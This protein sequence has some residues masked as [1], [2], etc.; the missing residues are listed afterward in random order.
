M[1]GPDTV[2][3]TLGFWAGLYI[4]LFL[5]VVVGGVALIGQ[6]VWETGRYYGYEQCRMELRQ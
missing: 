5:G 4:G 2:R 1:T 6:G 3:T